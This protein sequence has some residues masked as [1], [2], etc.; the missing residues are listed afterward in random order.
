MNK[1]EI[2]KIIQQQD[3]QKVLQEKDFFF[4]KAQIALNNW[5]A[6]TV[7]DDIKQ[8][9]IQ[10]ASDYK[11]FL[12]VSEINPNIDRIKVILFE[13]ISYCD[14][15]AKDKFKYNQYADF[16]ILADA[17]VRMGNW[18]AGLIKLKF[19]HSE[20]KGKSIINAFNYLLS[21]RDNCTILSDNHRKMVSEN[22]LNIPYSA[23]NFIN[24]LKSY[25][26]QF[27]LKFNNSDNYT[28]LISSLVYAFKNEWFDEVI[29][30]MAADGT[31]WQEDELNLD[32]IYDG[33]IIWNSKKPSGGQKTLNFLKDIIKDGQTFPIYYSIKGIVRYKA[34][35]TD[36]VI[37]QSELSA[38][39]WANLNIK[40][41]RSKFE[42]YKDESKKAYIV[43][44]ADTIEEINPM[45]IDN[46]KFYDNYTKPTQDNLS[47]IK[48]III[49]DST[50]KNEMK[51]NNSLSNQPLN[52][53]LYGPPGTG[54]T[55]H[56]LENILPLFKQGSIIKTPEVKEAEIISDLPWWKI[57]ALILLENGKQT[58]P[59]IKEHKYIKYKLAVSNTKSLN[60]TVWGQLSS[61]TIIE[62]DTVEY[63]LRAGSLIFN[64]DEQSLWFIAQPNHPVINELNEI[65]NEI[66]KPIESLHEA[67]NNYKFITFHQSTSYENFVEGIMPVLNDE[68]QNG[69]SEVQ[70]E[71]RKGIFYKACDEA[72]KLAG[73]LG[74]KECLEHT[75]EVRIQKF[76]NAK[77]YALFIDEINRGNISAILG[78][79]ITLIEED[80][81]LSKNE[82][83]LELPYSGNPFGV[84]PNLYIIGTMNTADRSVE[85]LDTALRRRFSFTEMQPLYKLPGLDYTI[86]GV[87]GHEI[88]LKI[89]KRIE[90][91]LDRDHLIGHSY[92]LLNG[93]DQVNPEDKLMDSFYRNIIPLLQEYFFGD[94]AKIG[95][96]LGKG[97]VYME[98]DS[99]EVDFAS[100]Y[101][102][103]DF[104]EKDLFQIID[105][106]PDQSGNKYVLNGM[107]FL[108]A[109]RLL[110]NL[111]TE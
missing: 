68:S 52:Q 86:S 89:N 103:N 40:Y 76:K 26:D 10:L 2:D 48:E 22:L 72:A 71:V 13:I 31:G 78:E 111:S 17:S 46:F 60:Q 94:Y 41:Y 9:L 88:L 77:P 83:I 42:D 43:F 99:D 74:V 57:F 38:K 24:D 106:R 32:R 3:F 55:F 53:I 66:N 96:V 56:L 104:V 107:S 37:N 23:N 28:Y 50:L 27:D 67:N 109:I 20:I 90:K 64:K 102:N 82:V 93:E 73:F 62:S 30:L 54:K 85:A 11:R 45:S 36:F 29:G 19:K 91:L 6:L 51:M 65:K 47:P 110:M 33:L 100:G 108:K 21:P 75:K 4:L 8:E 97:F 1:Q 25:F 7:S 14:N 87:K 63:G 84:P 44:H 34:T 98:N 35:I 59:Q 15:R 39:N 81:R 79:L 49:E 92:F 95:A 12:T 105:Y 80:K 5:L 58:V 69:I 16:R 101:E 70:Y 18:V 61:H